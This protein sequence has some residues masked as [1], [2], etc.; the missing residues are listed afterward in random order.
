MSHTPAVKFGQFDR[1]RGRVEAFE[2]SLPRVTGSCGR[3]F[4]FAGSFYVLFNLRP[5]LL[6]LGRR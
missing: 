3:L 5:R 1:L 4:G 2:T 6:C